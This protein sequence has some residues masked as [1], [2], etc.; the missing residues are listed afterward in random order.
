LAEG[1]LELVSRLTVRVRR[2]MRRNTANA[3]T[4]PQFRALR[5]FQRHPGTG[6][7]D[8]GDHLGM[9]LSSASALIERLS[10]AGYVHR[11]P[12]PIERRR[13]CV[14]LSESGAAVVTGAVL[15]TRV[16]MSEQLG[17]L[18]AKDR[19]ALTDTLEI[20]LRVA[21]TSEIDTPNPEDLEREERPDA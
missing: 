14:G 19:R 3:V 7:S 2:E 4:I 1:V 16:W 18:S 5:Y 10:R 15:G 6:P 9:S 20:L 11:T 21:A 12:H 13:I 17:N 8:L